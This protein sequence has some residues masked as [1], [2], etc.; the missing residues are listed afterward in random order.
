VTA[1]V[2]TGRLWRNDR[3]LRLWFGI[4]VSSVGTYLSIFALPTIAITLLHAQP[5]QIGILGAAEFIAAP[6]VGFLAGGFVDRHPTRLISVIADFARVATLASIPIAFATHN[7]T[8]WQL[9]AVSGVN[10]G[11]S[12]LFGAGILRLYRVVVRREDL[13]E[14]SI[15]LSASQAIGELGGPSLAGVLITRVG[16][17]LAIVADAVSY[18]V[19]GLMILSLPGHNMSATPRPF[20]GHATWKTD[21]TDGI[22]F[23]RSR[24]MLWRLLVA[25]SI[26]N[27]TF[28]MTMANWLVFAYGRLGQTPETVG[29]LTGLGELGAFL[30]IVL[31]LPLA[32]GIGTGWMLIIATLIGTLARCLIPLTLLGNPR[33]VIFASMFATGLSTTF[34]ILTSSSLWQS[35]TPIEL[36]GRVSAARYAVLTASI[37][38]GLLI[39][40]ALGSAIGVLPVLIIGAALTPLS[41]LVWFGVP[42]RKV[43]EPMADDFVD[44]TP[45]SGPTEM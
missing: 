35:L 9:Y 11:L 33:M 44:L 34:L 23:I 4:T 21:A 39:G 17:P 5:Y 8:L 45:A 32:R 18:L 27:F 6:F 13:V 24:P 1:S 3:F 20:D 2:I 22:R 29:L 36:L 26:L 15:K 40:G 38:L 28:Q 30:G 31:A 42:L 10:G 12:A 43:Y 7:L 37:A 25:T 41:A 16:A 14:A 19:S